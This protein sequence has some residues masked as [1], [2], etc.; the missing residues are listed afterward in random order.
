LKKIFILDTNVLLYDPQAIFKFPKSLIIIP[1]IVIEEIDTFKKDPNEN[2]RNS[3]KFS[4]YIDSLRKKGC[5]SEG[6]KLKNGS[7]LKVDLNGKI[8]GTVLENHLIFNTPDSRILSTAFHEKK[9][10]LDKQIILITKDINLRIKADI[11]KIAAKDYDIDKVKFEEMYSGLIELEADIDLIENLTNKKEIITH[12]LP[13]LYPNQY[14][15]LKNGDSKIA[16]RFD[17]K[18]KSIVPLKIPNNVFGI[19]PRNLEQS[20]ALDLLLNDEISLVSLIGRAGTGKTLMAVSA[21]LYKSLDEGIYNKLLVSRPIIPLGKDIGFLPGS[22]QEKL[23]PWM[24]PIFDNL[25]FI[26]SGGR[27]NSNNTTYMAKDLID[28]NRIIVE[29]LTYI[30]GRS[31]PS[32]FFTIDEAQ[33][34]SPHE[35][36]TILTRAGEGT[37]IILTGDCEQIDNP[38]LDASSNGLSYVVEKLKDKEITGHITLV[39]GERSEL[40]E[41]ASSS[42]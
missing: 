16:G 42:L 19:R 6:V 25:D 37:K 2:G 5:L 20:I 7:I 30:R 12:E 3:R 27:K 1:M 33:N 22:V 13:S 34:L 26:L 10:N 11:L 9:N 35:I 24:K 31:I 23:D 40:A 41:L 38:Y 21:G 36:K 8:A 39:K 29:P 17:A 18:K 4:R 14:I 28:K 32:Q 15:L